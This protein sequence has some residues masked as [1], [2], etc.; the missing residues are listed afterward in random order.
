MI[1]NHKFSSILV[2]K[3]SKFYLPSYFSSSPKLYLPT[4]PK[5]CVIANAVVSEGLI[6]AL[7]VVFLLGKFHSAPIKV[8]LKGFSL[9]FK[10]KLV[11]MN[12]WVP[13]NQI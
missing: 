9:L 11:Y 13:K 4:V 3:L 5:L 10:F 7:N 1:Y 6:L 8:W 12:E 2:P